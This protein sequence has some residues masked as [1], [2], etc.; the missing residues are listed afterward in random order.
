MGEQT[1]SADYVIKGAGATAMAFADTLLTETDATMV[2]VD[3]RDRPGGHWNDAYPFVRLHQPASSYGVPSTPL[4]SGRIDE[5]GLNA[6]YHELAAGQE[7][8]AHYDGVMRHRFLPSGRV[9]F[10]PMSDLDDDGTVT[11][12]L[13]GERT[14]VTA[15]RFVD[16]THSKMRVPSTSAPSFAVGADVAFVPLNQLPRVAASYERFVVI[17]AGKTGMDACVWLLENGAD[18]D[19]ITWVVPRDS[20][21]LNRANFQPGDEFFAR[22]T[23]SIADQVEAV[24]QAESVDDLFARLEACDELRRIDA[25]VTPEAYHCAILSDGELV[26]LRRIRNVVRMGHVTSIEADEIRL[27]HGTIPTSAS[28]LHVDCSAVGIPTHPSVPVFAGDRIT[29]QWVR[30]CQPTFSAAF[31]GHVEAAYDDEVE[32]NRRCTPIVPPTVPL[33]WLHMFKVE[34][35]T[36][37]V[38]AADDGIGHWLA[39]NRLDGISGTIRTRLG[40]DVEAT[41]HLGRYLTNIQPAAA[42]LDQLL[43]G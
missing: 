4:G 17:G 5:V 2:L 30:T 6:G 14:Q 25:T 7:V 41:E 26:Q 18:P 11:S 35:A 27:D 23:K 24:V 13:S 9:T 20:W 21:V 10:L 12:L 22:F 1:I 37:M 8:L 28:T 32:K 31:I 3:R 38:W 40:V 16:A 33:D 15:G 43:A 19:A 29:L 39:T 34:L 42:K 36:R